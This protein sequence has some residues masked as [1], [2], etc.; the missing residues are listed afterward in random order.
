MV[1]CVGYGKGDKTMNIHTQRDI[2]FRAVMRVIRPVIHEAAH[3][4]KMS[5]MFG[6]EN[7]NK[8]LNAAKET[9]SGKDCIAVHC[10]KVMA[11]VDL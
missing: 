2:S 11:L 10:D 6:S 4:K 9:N 3:D 1:V 7:W 5:K 8:F